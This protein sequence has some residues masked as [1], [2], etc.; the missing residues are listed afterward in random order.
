MLEETKNELAYVK[1][2][3]E[4]I[5]LKIDSYSKSRY[6][7]DHIIDIQKKKTDVTC[8]GYTKCPP[9]IR[10]NYTKMPDEEDKPHF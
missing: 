3:N 7:L 6:V 8:V 1:C 5:Q 10:N 2:E 4:E 9:P